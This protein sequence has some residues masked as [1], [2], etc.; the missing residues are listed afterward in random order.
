MITVVELLCSKSGYFITA[1]YEY[2][3]LSIALHLVH[4]YFG[5]FCVCSVLCHCPCSVTLLGLADL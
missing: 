4:L 3:A 2:I 1:S 5:V